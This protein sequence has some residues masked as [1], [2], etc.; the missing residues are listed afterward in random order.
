MPAGQ[1]G[2]YCS[3]LKTAGNSNATFPASKRTRTTEIL[4]FGLQ[5]TRGHFFRLD[6]HEPAM[7]AV[8]YVQHVCKH[9]PDITL[10]GPAYFDMNT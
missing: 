4:Q 9:E 5:L 8:V 6:V 1:K 3:N 10:S 7:L 2:I